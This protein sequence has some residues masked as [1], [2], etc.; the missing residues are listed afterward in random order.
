MRARIVAVDYQLG[1]TCITNSQ[2][3]TLSEQW[4]EEKIWQKTGV[5]Q[6]SIATAD[7]YASDLACHAAEHLFDRGLIRREEIDFLVYVTQSPDQL[8]PATACV[9]Q[10]RLGLASHCG[11]IEINQG[12]SG[13]VYGLGVVTGLVESG[14]A[15]HVLLLCADTVSRYLAPD[16][17]TVRTLFGDAGSATSIQAT[18]Q[19]SQAIGPFL[20]GTD[21]SG[22]ENLCVRGGGLRQQPDSTGGSPRMFMNGPEVFAFTMSAIP[23]AVQ[24][25][26]EQ[27][28]LTLTDIDLI[29]F[30]QANAF[31][32][33][34]L[35]SKLKVPKERFVIAMEHCGNTTSSSIPIAL[36]IAEQD[37]RL[38]SG[39]R[40]MVVGFG[41]GYSWSLALLNWP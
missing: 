7:E 18:T 9:I 17:L 28:Q 35:R 2:L 32:L 24:A 6:R 26:L 20:H 25:L 33:E 19:D 5:R 38:Q 16:D 37:S 4:T 21:G 1:K 41:V 34:H 31:I 29:V 13:Y 11:A 15:R 10:S 14:Q 22:A 40:V 30:H 27:A 12:C 8:M 39:M 36:R 23:K 3:A